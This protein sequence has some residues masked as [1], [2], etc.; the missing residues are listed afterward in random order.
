VP[1]GLPQGLVPL[2]SAFVTVGALQPHAT[3]TEGARRSGDPPLRVQYLIIIRGRPARVRAMRP[4]ILI[5]NDDG[6]DSPGLRAAA[7]AASTIGEVVLVAPKLPQTAM[8]RS[9]PR[10]EDQG[11]IETQVKGLGHSTTHY[12]AVSGSLRRLWLTRY[13]RYAAGGRHCA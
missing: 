5:T 1:R 10:T 11:I 4:L 3:F 12:H 13:L 7:E 2:R 6:V 9:F 8:G